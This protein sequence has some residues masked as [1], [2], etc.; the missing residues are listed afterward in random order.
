MYKSVILPLAKEDI[1]EA[2]K[3][4]NKQQNGLGKRFT[5]EVR[6]KVNF[7]RKNPRASNVRYND[8]RTAVLNVFPF[9]VHYSIDEINKTII[10]SAVLHT[11]RDPE[12][13]KN[14]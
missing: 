4:Y 7:I 8:V 2:A 3:W 1:R 5:T 11:S 12:I 13:W 14:R 6:E 10:V 9:L